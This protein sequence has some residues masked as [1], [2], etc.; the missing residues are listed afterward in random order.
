M[1]SMKFLGA[2]QPRNAGRWSGGGGP[3][4]HRE[5][6]DLSCPCRRDEEVR[7]MRALRRGTALTR[8]ERKELGPVQIVVLGFDNLTLQD[9]IVSELKR[10]R[11]LE[12]VR[13]VDVVVV[14]KTDSGDLVGVNA[15]E[16]D[17]PESSQFRGIAAALVGLDA[18]AEGIQAG[19]RTGSEVGEARGF[20]GD[21]QTWSVADA[22]PPGQLAV[23]ALLEHR[24]A[25]PLRDGVQRSGGETLADAWVHPDDLAFYGGMAAVTQAQAK[26]QS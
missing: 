25:I 16:L 23:V 22:I 11:K 13:L 5:P 14:T 6:S 3:D 17:E 9:G 2:T 26:K 24:W 1:T 19:A 8:A 18:A 20:L 7:T 15:S 21:E 12:I 10:L 4:Y